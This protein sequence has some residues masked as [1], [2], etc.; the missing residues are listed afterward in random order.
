M[1]VTRGGFL[2]RLETLSYFK[3][4]EPATQLSARSRAGSHYILPET[5]PK[6]KL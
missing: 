4:V 6:S 3:H 5:H 2:Q 1:P